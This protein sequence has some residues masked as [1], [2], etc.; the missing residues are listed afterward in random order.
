M[1]RLIAILVSL[2]LMFTFIPQ[3]KASETYFKF[4]YES[5]KQLEDL[6]RIISIDNV[7]GDTVFAFA[8]DEELAN[9]KAKG[10]SYEILPHPNTLTTVRMADDKDLILDWDVY[11][12]YTGYLTIMNDFE[13]DYPN[14]CQVEN[15]GY[16][17]E[18]RQI[19]FAKLS[20]NVNTEENEPEIMYSSTMHGDETTGYILML[21]LIDYLLSNYGTDPQ[22]TYMLNNSE[23]WI[24]PLA[25]PDGTYAG[26]N[27]TVNGATRY[28]ANGYDLNRNFPDPDDGQHPGGAW[29]P[30]TIDMMDFFD[31]HSFVISAN[32]HGGIEVVNYPW[33]TYQR[34]HP[35]NNW[36]VAISRE[37][38]DSAQANSPSGYMDDL[39]NGITNGYAWYEVDGGR[40]DYITY[41]KGGRETTIELSTTHLLPENQ[42][43]AHWNYNRAALI[44]YI[45]QSF[46]GIK[47][48]VTDFETGLPLAATISVIGH[49]ADS[50]EVYTDPD[51]GDYHRMISAGTYSLRFT[52]PGYVP[53]TV[54]NISVTTRNVTVVNVQLQ[55]M[56]D[57]PVLQFLSH[58][59]GRVMPTDSI[60]MAIIL[61]NNG[62]GN[63]SGISA[64]LST[65]DEYAIVTQST[66][67]YPSITAL[68]GTG[69]SYTDYKFYVSASCPETH[70]IDFK[71]NITAADGYVDSAFFSILANVHIENFETGNFLTFPW[72][73][74]GDGDWVIASSGAYE[75]SYCGKSG[76]IS[77]NQ[78]SVILLEYDV[79]AA[80]TISFYYKVSSEATYD[81]FRFYI[82]GNMRNEWSGE[83]GWAI[84]RYPVSAGTH[85]FKWEYDKDYSVSGGSDCGWIDLIDFPYVRQSLEIITPSLP[86]WTIGIP[87]S[88]QLEVSGGVGN[89]TWSDADGDLVGT[90]LNLSSAGLLSGSPATTGTISFTA[91]VVDQASN[92]DD[93]LFNF[94]INAAP[95]II[96]VDLPDW[97]QGYPYSYQLTA[98]GGT[99]IKTW[100][101]L[102]GDLDGTG[103]ALS[104]GGL[105]SGT[106]TLA[107]PIDFTAHIEDD[108]G[109]S[110]TEVF[111]FIINPG[112]QI[113]TDT[114]PDWTVGI[115]Y[116]QQLTATG[117]TGNKTWSDLDDDLAEFGLTI[118]D[119][120]LV[121]GLPTSI[122]SVSFTANIEDAIGASDQQ[123]LNFTLNPE[124]Q[125]TTESLP[126][127]FIG[128]PYSVQLEAMG[129]TGT[130]TYSDLNSDLEG[131][132][133]EL[134]SS[135][136]ISG[137]PISGNLITFTAAVTDI[138]GAQTSDEFSITIEFSYLAGDANGDDH[139][140]GSDV[141]YLVQYLRGITP[142]PEP[143]LA[144]DA[145]GDCVVTGPDVTFLVNYFR[146]I[147]DPPIY[148]D[149]PPLAIRKGESISK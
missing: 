13:T 145:N 84:A 96:T 109:A 37:Y 81:F 128:Q 118:S 92:Y 77:H 140:I 47:G 131:T 119:G 51:V 4:E 133:L 2:I 102:N 94:T 59:A 149:C 29:Q 69:M 147:G 61:I 46:Y 103:L 42:L 3:A 78:N 45:E 121:V 134:I 27:N 53:Q 34:L 113:T 26:G 107:G 148:G 124:P 97:T 66:S 1:P 135:G 32:F 5:R 126:N 120:G 54:S 40:Q 19:L 80:D 48:L 122:G 20:A 31:E 43:L 36:F 93:K 132:G 86:D 35:D 63:A 95:I 127:G 16:T 21:H 17:V 142:E 10:Y 143:Y 116:A 123:Q 87:Y 9:F 15:I 114:L 18:G 28:N 100:S 68:G 129:G 101:D 85:T 104:S 136:L 79:T 138:P 91:H 24:N 8:N 98:S 83:V 144:G 137:T 38:A 99:G 62:A 6:S 105:I 111:D 56:S 39:N 71:L 50:S 67:T 125:I 112:L 117:G 141:T 12:T 11:P 82:D 139:V 106:P 88:Q 49:D 57:D 22:I 146:G 55:P 52:S 130:L 14:L 33:D 70:L 76:S 25:N 89:L 72:A 41:W 60:S 90:G 30:E 110:D 44:T 75:G 64:S 58:D 7:K 115:Q 65:E 73:M 74:D 108:P 23:V